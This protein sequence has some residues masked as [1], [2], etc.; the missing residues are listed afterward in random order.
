MRGFTNRCAVVTGAAQGIGYAIAKR[1]VEEGVKSLAIVDWN[2]ENAEKA[3]AELQAIGQTTVKAYKCDV[4]SYENVE[5]TFSR[6][7]ADLGPVDI[8]V[9]NAGITRDV[10]FHKMTIEQWDA[11]MRVNLYGVF[12]CCRVVINGMR[13]REYGR[14]V[15]MS[16]TSAY[17]NPGQAN[18]AATKAGIIG[19]TKTLARESARKGITVNAIAPCQIHT[20]MFL[21]IPKDLLDHWIDIHPMKRL[22][23]AEEVASLTAYLCSDD[24]TYV[25]GECIDCAG[26]AVT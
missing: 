9:N 12:N 26:A 14:I 7:E 22:G 1:L 8:L 5:E 17:G 16:S 10:I 19:F 20:D 21:A 3:A 23:T 13:Q 24:C 6:I 4:G 15:N 25:N 2:G 11:V 18:Y